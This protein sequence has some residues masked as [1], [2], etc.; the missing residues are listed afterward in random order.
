MDTP[1]LNQRE[2]IVC[3]DRLRGII[4]FAMIFFQLLKRF[5]SLGILSRIASH[6]IETGILIMPGMVI[7]DIIAPLFFM[8][9]SL[10]YIPSLKSRIARDGRRAAYGHFILRY[11]DLIGFGFALRIIDIIVNDDN[12][13]Y[14]I[15]S[16]VIVVI[17]LLAGIGLLVSSLV[18]NAKRFG[19]ICQKTLFTTLAVLGIICCIVSSVDAYRIF[20]LEQSSQKYWGV[21][22]SIGGAGLLVL[23]FAEAGAVIRTCAAVTI[24]GTFS[25]IHELPGFM[26][27]ID[28]DVQGGVTGILGWGSMMLAFTV[29]ADLFWHDRDMKKQGKKGIMANAYL[30]GTAVTIALGIFGACTFT[31]NK[32]SV[33]PG[34]ILVSLPIC[35]V[36]FWL[37]SLTDAWQPKFNFFIWWGTSPIIMYLLQY[38]FNDVLMTLVSG[39]EDLPYVPALLFSV[40]ITAIISYVAYILYKKKQ[41]IRF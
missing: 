33:S 18:K 38:I 8:A 39:I 16:F 22:Q 37:I 7:A 40:V 41:A 21:L 26:E 27:K 30:L 10:N 15:A 31:I 35:A 14:Q 34:Y 36:G 32:G 29:L 11:L 25:F 20:Y 5:D 28:V 9:I 2:R 1:N 24:F 6:D 12:V 4:I 3:I 19:E 23:L 13:W 17:A